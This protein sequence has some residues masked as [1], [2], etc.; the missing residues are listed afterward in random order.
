[1]TDRLTLAAVTLA[2]LLLPIT[3]NAV[4]RVR[5]IDIAV[6]PYYQAA[7]APGDAPRVSVNRRFD[8][9]LSS[10]SHRDIA[11]IRDMV[12]AD[13]DMLPPI[14]LM[15]LAVRLYDVGLRDDA[16]F[17]FYVARARQITLEDV[18]DIEAAGMRQPTEGARNFARIA[19]PFIGGYA[20]C[21]PAQ[22][23]KTLDKAIDWVETHPYNVIFAERIP[24]R[25]GERM[26]NLKRSIQQQRDNAAKE[27]AMYKDPQAAREF[28][29]ARK[30]SGADEAF[31][32]K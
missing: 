30:R 19:A 8:A 10:T 9:A 27:L 11:E 13:P 7:P 20:F 6:P 29:A 21:D 28:A 1:M 26:E 23:S 15:V 2:V 12:L 16:V 25:P 22:R 4:E 32:W 31:C 14:A 18:L 17:W 24:T 5:H 3:G